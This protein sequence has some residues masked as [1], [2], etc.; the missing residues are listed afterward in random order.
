[1]PNINYLM[2]PQKEMYISQSYDGPYSHIKYS[3]GVPASYPVDMVNNSSATGGFF[4]PCDEMEIVKLQNRNAANTVPYGIWLTSTDR[5]VLSNGTQQ[6]VTI[7]WIH[8][9]ADDYSTFYVGKKYTRGQYITNQGTSGAATGA[10]IEQQIGLG[11]ISPPGGQR[12]SKGAYVLKTSGKLIKP[13]EAMWVNDAFTTAIISD[14]GLSFRH[15]NG[16]EPPD[17]PIPPDPPA[18]P[19]PPPSPWHPLTHRK[20]RSIFWF[21]GW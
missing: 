1:M 13:E 6:K 9:N 8:M 21:L 16:G 12:N 17:P 18:P 10:H 11:V 4:C 20:H 5:V 2:W 14:K 7:K 15:Y 19:D 3:T